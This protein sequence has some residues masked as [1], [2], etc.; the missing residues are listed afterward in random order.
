M[1]RWRTSSKEVKEAA[2]GMSKQ[3]PWEVRKLS[4]EL[5]LSAFN[6]ATRP[7]LAELGVALLLDEVLKGL[8]ARLYT[9]KLQKLHEEASGI[10]NE[11]C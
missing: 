7:S 9:K 6:S 4:A 2:E 10:M 1:E 3:K 5:A 11:G 8:D